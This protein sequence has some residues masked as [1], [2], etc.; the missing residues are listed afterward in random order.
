[1][2]H[3]KAC[4]VLTSNHML[5]CSCDSTVAIERSCTGLPS[6][7]N[8]GPSIIDKRF[9]YFRFFTTLAGSEPQWYLR[10]LELHSLPELGLAAIDLDYKPS[11]RKDSN[12]N[13]FRYRAKVTDV[14]GSQMGRWLYDV[15]LDARRAQLLQE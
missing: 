13:S 15:F 14:H 9:L 12:N 2:N 4:S 8:H 3:G 1:M 10:T 5:F 6:L 7:C 11:K